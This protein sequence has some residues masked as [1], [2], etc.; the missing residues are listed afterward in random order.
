MEG[1]RRFG[2][3]LA[4]VGCFVALAVAGVISVFA[5]DSVSSAGVPQ[6]ATA[7]VRVDSD[8]DGGL[9]Q[10]TTLG[11][12]RLESGRMLSAG[13]VVNTTS[14]QLASA[15]TGSPAV[16]GT[17]CCAL[18]IGWANGSN[19]IDVVRCAPPSAAGS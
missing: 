18:R 10:L 12:V 7:L 5:F 9:A 6:L 16:G 3:L 14:D 11:A 19:V 13:T 15:S 1:R 4:L 2:S 17:L 8:N